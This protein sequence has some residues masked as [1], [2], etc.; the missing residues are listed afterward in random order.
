MTSSN[1]EPNIFIALGA[2]IPSALGPPEMTLASA[3]RALAR[4]GVTIQCVS[5][6]HHTPAWPDPTDPPFTNAAAGIE[7]VLK[8]MELMALLHKVE[9]DHGRTRSTKNAPRT[10]DL[11]LI[12][13]QGLVQGGP[14]ILP[15]P[16]M[17]ERRFVLEPLA[18]IA[19]H[20]HHP[21]TGKSA[22]ELLTALG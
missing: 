13:Y 8:P 6:F 18:E 9:T 21:V 3:L 19:P 5:R 12:D 2:N 17:A 1:R 16:R 11:D 20:W 4:A 14:P 22:A 7:T 10:L 15:H